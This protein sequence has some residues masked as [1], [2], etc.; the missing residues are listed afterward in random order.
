MRKAWGG[1][2]GM[3]LVEAEKELELVLGH[4]RAGSRRAWHDLCDVYLERWKYSV[5]LSAPCT[6]RSLV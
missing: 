2:V 1:A 6:G 3:M 5:I 4:C